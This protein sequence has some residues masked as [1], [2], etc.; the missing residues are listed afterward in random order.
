M[1]YVI[2]LTS[3]AG[4]WYHSRNGD[5]TALIARAMVFGTRSKAEAFMRQHRLDEEYD[6]FGEHAPSV[7]A[8]GISNSALMRLAAMEDEANFPDYY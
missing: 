1:V 4:T 6:P 3:Y 5:W 2:A 8:Y 7:H